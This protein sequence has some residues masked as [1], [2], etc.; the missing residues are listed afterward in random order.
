MRREHECARFDNTLC[1]HVRE[2]SKSAREL[3]M[4]LSAAWLFAWIV[5][6]M[7]HAFVDSLLGP[8]FLSNQCI[9]RF[10]RENEPKRNLDIRLIHH[11]GIH[12]TMLLLLRPKPTP[13]PF[14]SNK[15]DDNTFPVF[16]DLAANP[17]LPPKPEDTNVPRRNKTPDKPLH[18]HLQ[19]PP[20]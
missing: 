5:L 20:F 7:D 14:T 11:T 12:K 13:V 4:C 6:P 9:N 1:I 10:H 2:L 18:D 19:L 16:E 3:S 8:W 17:S 15:M